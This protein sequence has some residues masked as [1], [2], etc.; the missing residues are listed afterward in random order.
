LLR[1]LL[2]L[3]LLLL[4]LMLLPLI[5]ASWSLTDPR[6]PFARNGHRWRIFAAAIDTR[7]GR[8]IARGR[9]AGPRFSVSILAGGDIYFAVIVLVGFHVFKDLWFGH[10]Q[11]HVPAG[12]GHVEFARKQHHKPTGMAN[13]IGDPSGVVAGAPIKIGARRSDDR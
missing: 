9:L 1:Q 4:L 6:E 7:T 13:A 3:T 12:F 8:A 5:A 11:R 2:F 10:R